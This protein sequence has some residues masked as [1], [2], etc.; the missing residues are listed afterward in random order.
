M[1]IA[2][3]IS[4][5]KKKG[6]NKKIRKLK[7]WHDNCNLYKRKGDMKMRHILIATHGLLASG[8]R[9]TMEFLIGN[10]DNVDYITAYVDG[11]KPI[12]EQIEEYFAKIPQEDEVVIFTDIKGGS[13]N[14]KMIPYCVRENT[15]LVSGFNLAVLIEVTMTPEK[16]T[17]EFLKAKIEE[18]REQLCLVEIEKNNTEENDDDFLL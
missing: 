12:N 7:S 3:Y 14:Q 6:E 8:A 5:K 13:V 1:T 4:E 11:Q 2:V 15:F 17:N 9:S 16:L 18:A 10:V